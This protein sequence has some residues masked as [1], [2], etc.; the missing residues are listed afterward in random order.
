MKKI[1]VLQYFWGKLDAGG[2]E[3]LI[4]NIFREMDKDKFDVD[5]LVYEN[6]NF[7]YT[8]IIEQ[9]GGHV[10]PLAEVESK[11]LFVRLIKRWVSLYKLLKERKYDVFHCNCD[12]SMK[13]IELAIAKIAGVPI[14]VCHSHN[15]SLDKTSLKGKISYFVHILFRPL[16]SKYATN[17]L[18]C[19]ENAAVWLFGK[20]VAKEKIMITHNGINAKYYSYDEKTRNEM[21]HELNLNNE[22]VIGH[23]GRFTPIKNQKF[24]IDLAIEA[25]KHKMPIKIFLIGEGDLKLQMEHYA[26][27]C[28]VDDNVYFVGTTKR[29]RDYLMAFDCFVLPSLYE[30]LP[31]SGIEAQA[32]GLACVVSDTVTKDLDIT[33][34]VL[35]VSL[36]AGPSIWLEKILQWINQI[37]RTDVSEKIIVHGYD[38][39]SLAKKI[40]VIYKG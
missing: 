37:E 30:G 22:L 25:K 3:S 38:I 9:L 5:F 18:A 11:V 2:A 24:M 14:R 20:G 26:I 17:L 6:K 7:F 29:V 27:T 31:V 13:F 12:F 21:R 33:G 32:S 40:E 4:V 23:I 15:S 19:S 16:V 34:N 10:V 8:D 39:K 28:G 35:F 36:N 1:K